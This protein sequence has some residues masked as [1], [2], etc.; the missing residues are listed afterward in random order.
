MLARSFYDRPTLEVA[1]DLIG[2]HI[3]YYSGEGKMS[4]RIVEVEAYIGRD[5]PACHA[6]NGLTERNQVM[7]GKAGFSYVYFIYGM[8]H[9][10][11]FVTEAE[12][13]PAAVLLRAA[14]PGEGLD[15]MRRNSPGQSD[16]QLLSGPGKF[17]RSFGLTREHN[18][19]DLTNS[20]LVIE[21]RGGPSARVATSAR[22]GIK[23]AAK[24]PWRFFDAGSSSV[25]RS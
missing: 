5:D 10:L 19:M 15:I 16:A 6:S 14:E 9:C 21:N 7:F 17:C 18:G 24:R 11:N 3:V 2:K 12:G 4:A 23:K 1:R 8:Y 13:S 22:V 25:S 20:L